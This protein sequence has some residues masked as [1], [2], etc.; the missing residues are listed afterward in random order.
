VRR[1][2]AR[3]YIATLSKNLGSQ[4]LQ[5]VCVCKYDSSTKTRAQMQCECHM[6]EKRTGKR[7]QENI[8]SA[9]DRHLQNRTQVARKCCTPHKKKHRQCAKCW[10]KL[11]EEKDSTFDS[12]SYRFSTSRLPVSNDSKGSLFAN[13]AML[14]DGRPL[15]DANDQPRDP[16]MG[17]NSARR[18]RSRHGGTLRNKQVQPT[19]AS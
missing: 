6:R 19:P 7:K 10:S 15:L 9:L 17:P 12:S 1:S 2:L 8:V 13:L 11:P 18:R 16:H 3:L 5:C 14:S 4:D